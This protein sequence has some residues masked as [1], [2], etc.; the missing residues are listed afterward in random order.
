MRLLE[1]VPV[2]QI[3]HCRIL[4]A[5]FPVGTRDGRVE[6]K[7]NQGEPIFGEEGAPGNAALS[8]TAALG[9]TFPFNV[10]IGIPLYLKLAQSLG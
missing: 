6:V 3:D 9:V 7:A 8:I 4:R 10:L 1:N 2:V 5:G